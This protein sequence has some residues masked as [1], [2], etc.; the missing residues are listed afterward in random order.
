MGNDNKEGK[1]Q[2]GSF[3]FCACSE[4]CLF[5]GKIIA[6]IIQMVIRKV[7]KLTREY[8]RS[9]RYSE[10]KHARTKPFALRLKMLLWLNLPHFVSI[11]GE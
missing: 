10:E 8:I 7:F 6:K 3:L 1:K 5:T 4:F 9:Y 2:H 11:S